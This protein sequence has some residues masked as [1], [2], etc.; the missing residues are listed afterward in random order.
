MRVSQ[1]MAIQIT[2]HDL[3]VIGDLMVY[4]QQ[5]YPMYL[6]FVGSFSTYKFNLC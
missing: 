2:Q 5:N 3:L 4:L 1:S 6:A